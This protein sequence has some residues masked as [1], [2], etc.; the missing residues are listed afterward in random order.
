MIPTTVAPSA[1]TKMLLGTKSPWIQLTGSVRPLSASC[2]SS[3]SASIVPAAQSAV[4]PRRPEAL[5]DK[6]RTV[7]P[8]LEDAVVYCA[9][10]RRT[11]M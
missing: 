9:R 10:R 11:P 2:S 4:R 1:E 6:R 8:A 5:Q 3:T 7:D